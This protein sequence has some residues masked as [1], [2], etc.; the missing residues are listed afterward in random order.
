MSNPATVV[1][2][3]QAISAGLTGLVF[4]EG[5]A[6]DT[7]T[8]QKGAAAVA[9]ANW[10]PFFW[11]PATGVSIANGEAVVTGGN[12]GTAPSYYAETGTGA[13]MRG[14]FM[15]G[16]FEA[17]FKFNATGTSTPQQGV[18]PAFWLFGVGAQAA[19]NGNQVG[20]IDGFEAYPGN[21]A[22]TFYAIQTLHNWQ[23]GWNGG[24]YLSKTD[25]GNT[26][27]QNFMIG[28]VGSAEV[29][30]PNDGNFHTYGIL[31]KS[32]GPGTGIIEFYYDNFLVIHTGNVTQYAVGA[33]T[34]FPATET[35]AMGIV[36][37]GGITQPIT[38]DFVHVFQAPLAQ[39]LAFNYSVSN[40]LVQLPAE[41][42]QSV[43]LTYSQ[44][45]KGSVSGTVLT[46][47]AGAGAV[48]VQANAPATAT[49]PAF[50]SVETVTVP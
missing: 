39:T 42:D 21:T 31:W 26:N 6:A 4:N 29:P 44:P 10:Y 19:V 35:N 2:P 9:G 7:Y 47:A 28:L 23:Y 49:L 24:T 1:A 38:V 25:T 22:G 46:V 50:S 33:G 20:E 40:V 30:N 15:H 16:Y 11:V 41:T 27:G 18:W 5:F 13:S 8:S 14:T 36:L 17:R 34:K 45:S 43:P 12:I 32:T 37:Q 3:S 48:T